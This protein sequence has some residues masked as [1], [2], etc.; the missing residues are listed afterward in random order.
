ML[1]TYESSGFL[2]RRKRRK[3]LYR[4][5]LAVVSVGQEKIQ[6]SITLR[7]RNG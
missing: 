5:D 4:Y 1:E 2:L 6:E 3:S 7:Y